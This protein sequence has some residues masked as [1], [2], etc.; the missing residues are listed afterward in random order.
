VHILGRT[1]HPTGAWTTQQARNLLMDLDD[2]ATTFRFLVRDRAGQFTTSFDAVLAGARDRHREDPAA[3]SRANCYA[4]VVLVEF[5]ENAGRNP[6]HRLAAAREQLLIALVSA[7]SQ[8]REKRVVYFG[9]PGLTGR[10]RGVTVRAGAVE[11]VSLVAVELQ[12]SVGAAD[13]ARHC[14]EGMPRDSRGAG[15]SGSGER[16]RSERWDS[17]SPGEVA[18]RGR[19]LVRV[20]LTPLPRAAMPATEGRITRSWSAVRRHG[21]LSDMRGAPTVGRGVVTPHNAPP[22]ASA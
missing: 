14:A 20:G 18:Y 6:M 5:G 7:G 15:C 22:A 19:A 17:P 10:P 12:V 1:S 4:E 13:A 9:Q 16:S 11:E 21:N 8:P 2:R 3:L